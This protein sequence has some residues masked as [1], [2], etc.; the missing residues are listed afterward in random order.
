MKVA[1]VYDRVNKWGGAERVLLALH[2]LFP[3]APLYTSVYDSQK[4]PWASVFSVKTSF[5]QHLPLPKDHHELYPFLMGPA[6]EAFNFDEFDLVISVTSEYAK[7]V[8]TK[9]KTK[10]ICLCLTP[11]GYLWSNYDSY[12]SSKSQW[13][14]WLST[15]LVKWLRFYDRII[16]QRPDSYIAIS[17]IVKERIETYYKRSSTVI[18]PFLEFKEFVKSQQKPE[19]FYLLVSRLV[20]NKRLDVAITAF[21]QLGW[22]LKIVGVGGE[23]GRLK[24]LAKANIEFVGYLTDTKL[25][26]Y[27]RRTKALIVPGAEDFGL[28]ALEAQ[29]FG[30]PVIALAK[31]GV[32]ETVIADKTGV[33]YE[34]QTVVGL[35]EALKRFESLTFDP[36]DCQKQAKRFSKEK[37]NRA[38]LA[39]IDKVWCTVS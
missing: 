10:H 24:K 12:F 8:I 6:F 1:L 19:N 14:K 15:P 39:Y 22:P 34:D 23:M 28:V 17:E 35:L 37:F 2:E 31:G 38:V 20:P 11:T 13:F 7:A 21:N 4:A 5:L 25:A 32:L 18:Y 36:K 16:A 27:Y 3:D 30:K 26:S 9:P 33:L 29:S